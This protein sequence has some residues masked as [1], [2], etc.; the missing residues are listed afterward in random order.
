MNYLD[1]FI[2]DGRVQGWTARSANSY[3]Y[4]IKVFLESTNKDPV[5]TDEKDLK[6]FLKY[7]DARGLSNVTISRY[8]AV[9]SSFFKFL[10]YEELV[11]KNPVP[12]FRD[13]YLKTRM[14]NKTNGAKR[15]L[16]TVEQMRD[17]VNIYFRPKRQ[18]NSD[19][20]C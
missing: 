4:A 18:S 10:E 1:N 5:D 3:F 7:L 14:K 15:Q 9:L 8:F 17:L 6:T 16:I 11:N 19:N 12:R 20:T 13:R 2:E